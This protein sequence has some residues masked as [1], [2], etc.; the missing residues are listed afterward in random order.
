MRGDPSRCDYII[1]AR[2]LAGNHEPASSVRYV[3]SSRPTSSIHNT[4]VHT[5]SLILSFCSFCSRCCRRRCCC[6]YRCRPCLHSI[7][8]PIRVYGFACSRVL[9]RERAYIA[10]RLGAF[11]CTTSGFMGEVMGIM[12]PSLFLEYLFLKNILCKMLYVFLIFLK[13]LIN[14]DPIYT[15]RKK[16][17]QF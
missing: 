6:C 8:I 11:G 1:A 9:L 12:T 3:C 13:C 4:R 17:N 10:T 2:E 16:Y 15:L 14:C 7:L 5:R